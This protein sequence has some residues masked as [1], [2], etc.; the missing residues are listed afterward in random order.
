MILIRS[1]LQKKREKKSRLHPSPSVQHSLENEL[2]VRCL[3][4]GTSFFFADGSRQAEA[5]EAA[6]RA[7]AA[8]Q[9]QAT[10]RGRKARREA[11]KKREEVLARISHRLGFG[12]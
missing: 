4:S 7:N 3:K 6:E 10:E 12:Y 1:E 5:K 9:L 8:T 2:N 11:G